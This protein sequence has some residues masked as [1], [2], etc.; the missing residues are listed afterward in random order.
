MKRNIAKLVTNL[1]FD[2]THLEIMMKNGWTFTFDVNNLTIYGLHYINAKKMKIKDFKCCLIPK[3]T[4]S[5]SKEGK[6]NVALGDTNSN[7]EVDNFS[8]IVDYHL[9]N[10]LR[11]YNEK[12]QFIGIVPYIPSVNT[13]VDCHINNDGSLMIEIDSKA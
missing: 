11:F 2:F 3:G 4:I 6:K 7:V 5:I 9:I 1:N 13:T 10:C 8:K 12:K